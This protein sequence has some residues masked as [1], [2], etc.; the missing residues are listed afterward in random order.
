MACAE[1][2]PI[3]PLVWDN[4]VF[5]LYR[6]GDAYMTS[7]VRE[8]ALEHLELPALTPIVVFEAHQGIEKVRFKNGSLDPTFEEKERQL[9]NF[10]SELPHLQLDAR[11]AALSAFLYPRLGGPNIG[12]LWKD[13]FIAATAHVHDYGIAT[14]NEKD[15]RAIG[16][17][18]PD[19]LPPLRLAIWKT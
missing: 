16:T 4:D 3:T 8:Y 5:T 9:K 7:K 12:K 6:N 14:K 10:I 17:L 18:I 19:S 2:L 13:M 1:A 11:V 15:F